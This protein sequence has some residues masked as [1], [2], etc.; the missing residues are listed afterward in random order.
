[1]Q[2]I[3]QTFKMS[4]QVLHDGPQSNVTKVIFLKNHLNW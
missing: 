3:T 1:M 4:L 2:N